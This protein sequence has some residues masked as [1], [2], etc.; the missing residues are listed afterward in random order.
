MG[1]FD[2]LMANLQLGISNEILWD[3]DQGSLE[4]RLI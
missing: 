4:D 1:I 2:K 3:M